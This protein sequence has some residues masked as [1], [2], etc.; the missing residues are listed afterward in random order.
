MQSSS[1]SYEMKKWNMQPL[2]QQRSRKQQQRQG[3]QQTKQQ[4]PV[5]PRRQQLVSSQTTSSRWRSSLGGRLQV[6]LADGSP[7]VHM[8]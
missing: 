2:Q 1:S 5:R 6:N 7:Y 8:L 3:Q 4:L